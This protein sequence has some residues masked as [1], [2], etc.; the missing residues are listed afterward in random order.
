MPR[1]NNLFGPIGFESRKDFT[2]SRPPIVQ[3]RFYVPIEAQTIGTG[4]VP[5]NNNLFGP[6]GFESLKDFNQSRPPIVQARFYVPIEAQT[7]GADIEANSYNI[8]VNAEFEA[9]TQKN[10][11]AEE[12]QARLMVSTSFESEEL[13]LTNQMDDATRTDQVHFYYKQ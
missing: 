13:G 4:S 8:D 6:I 11:E 7:T 2:H 3:A 1:N 12:E 9:Q 10:F 5:R